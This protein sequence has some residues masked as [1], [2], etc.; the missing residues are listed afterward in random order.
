MP[1]ILFRT[2]SNIL[3][4]Q[5]RRDILILTLL[6]FLRTFTQHLGKLMVLPKDRVALFI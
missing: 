5:L 3:L 6:E 1:Q 4:E 2:L